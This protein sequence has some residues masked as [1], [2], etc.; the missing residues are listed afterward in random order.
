MLLVPGADGFHTQDS[1]DADLAM[2]SYA[3]PAEVPDADFRP[4]DERTSPT[5]GAL[6]GQP[7][8]AEARARLAALGGEN[9]VKSSPRRPEIFRLCE[10]R[11][12]EVVEQGH[13]AEVHV[14]LLVA[15]EEREARIVGDEVHL[16][17]LVAA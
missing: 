5:S 6:D 9:P 16:R 14:E 1:C 4:A 17:F 13:E 2:N 15:V 7:A 8:M 12:L 11:G 3:K 10:R